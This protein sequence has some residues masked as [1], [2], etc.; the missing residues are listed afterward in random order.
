MN[1]RTLV[2]FD[3]SGT[4]SVKA[5]LFSHS[6]RLNEELKRAGLTEFGVSN[7]VIFWDKIVVPTWHEAVTSGIG[8]ETS[9]VA[10]VLSLCAEEPVDVSEE[11]VRS[12]VERFVRGYMESLTIE[13]EWY[14]LLRKLNED[15]SIF[16]IVATD[17]YAEATELIVQHFQRA[18]IRCVPLGK[19]QEDLGCR[20]VVA[21]SADIGFQKMDV[22]YWRTCR[23]LL[24]CWEL[25]RIL[26][27]DDFRSHEPVQTSIAE[28]NG[29]YYETVLKCIS[30][31]FTAPVFEFF[32]NVEVVRSEEDLF[33]F[34]SKI[35]EVS[36][37]IADLLWGE[38]CSTLS[39]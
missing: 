18:N 30:E 5:V 36:H 7:D 29:K 37:S 38:D 1:I 31:V 19:W 14:P 15:E 32:F 11:R 12:A 23:A 26:V 17:H 27:I 25:E 34:K 35:A 39:S 10:Q 9:M 4:L 20:F 21:N 3:F 16:T 33:K 8:Y 22:R 28:Y 2:I 13:E 6:A 24:P